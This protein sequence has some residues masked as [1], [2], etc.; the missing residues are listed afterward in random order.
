MNHEVVPAVVLAKRFGVSV[1]TIQR[2]IQ[3]IE[4][5]G[6]PIV[7]MQGSQ[8]GYGILKSYRMDRQLVRANEL[9]HIIIALQSVC[10]TLADSHME[11]TLEKMKTLLFPS[12]LEK[13][14]EQ[15]SK[16]SIDFSL[17]GGFPHNHD[18]IQIVR[19]AIDTQHLLSFSYTNNNLKQTQRV[20]EP[21][22]LAFRWRS[23][24]LF[25]WCRLRKEYRLFKLT[26]IYSPQILSQSF[27]RKS[28]TFAEFEENQRQLKNM[29]MI[30]LTLRFEPIMRP[31]VE[32]YYDQAI[33]HEL[34]DGSLVVKMQIP[35]DQWVY[36][37]ILSYGPYVTVIEPEHVRQA[38]VSLAREVV[39]KYEQQKTSI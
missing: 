26:R 7:A 30:D 6:I 17:L 1:R 4:L 20:V 19:K 25:A 21:M 3:T 14:D 24:Y 39:N 32:E 33:S 34:D 13:L 23:W 31:L 9:C 8:G 11:T 18:V 36:G 22:T 5:A 2:D 16:L 12:D 35:D 37:F 28:L 38:I 29:P 27:E 10:K 15:H